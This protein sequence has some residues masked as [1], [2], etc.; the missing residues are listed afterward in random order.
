MT[1]SLTRPGCHVT[2]TDVQTALEEVDAAIGG[3]GIARR[4]LTLPVTCHGSAIDTPA[5]CRLGL[6]TTGMRSVVRRTRWRRS[7]R[8]HCRLGHARSTCQ[9]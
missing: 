3:G 8:R 9:S 1:V 5:S 2:A 4:S 6:R 7:M